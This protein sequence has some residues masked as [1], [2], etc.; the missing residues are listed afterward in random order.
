M[1]PYVMAAYRSSRHEATQY[2]PNYLM[3]G[4]EV[5]A[6]VDIVYGYPQTQTATNYDDYA[7]ELEERL[8]RAYSFVRGY[9]KKAAER[10]KKYYD[11]RVREKRYQVGDWVYCYQ[12]RR[13]QGRQEK[14]CRKFR[15]PFL[16]TSA[17][18]ESETILCTHRQG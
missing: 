5:H 18:Q 13:H 16:V 8:K 9:L 7:E 14:W 2:T 15:G 1:L 12:S 11:L 4:R 6:P 3:L 10:N 17:I